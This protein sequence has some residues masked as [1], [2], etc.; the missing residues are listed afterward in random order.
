MGIPQVMKK[1][2]KRIRILYFCWISHSSLAF[3][4]KHIVFRPQNV[5]HHGSF[6]FQIMENF[7]DKV[8]LSSGFIGQ[9]KSR[10]SCY[11]KTSVT[12]TFIQKS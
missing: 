6:Y 1:E 12:V 7:S 4:G 5:K 11:N 3:G 10:S 2:W 9:T 8:C